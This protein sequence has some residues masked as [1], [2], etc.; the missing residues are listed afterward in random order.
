M[1]TLN[2]PLQLSTAFKPKIWGREDLSPIYSSPEETDSPASR[3]A[4]I[5]SGARKPGEL[6]GEVWVTDDTS[7]FLNGPVAGLTLSEASEKY[8]PELHGRAWKGRRFPL[9]AKYV[10]T[11]DWLSVQVHPDDD[12]ARTHDPGN[13]GKCEMWYIIHADPGAQ[14]LLGLKAGATKEE[15]KAAFGQGRS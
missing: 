5:S 4:E 6:I 9:L 2:I 10:F 15:L 1:S 14:I 12:Y 7:R 13:L 11:S 3:K 8:G